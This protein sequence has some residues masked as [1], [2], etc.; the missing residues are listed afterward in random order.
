MPN[1]PAVYA[2]NVA[3]RYIQS[4][5]VLAINAHARPLVRACLDGLKK[6]PVELITPDE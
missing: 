1:Y 2:V 6:L 5:G 4:I 3:L